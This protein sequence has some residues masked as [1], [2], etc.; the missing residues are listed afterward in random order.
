MEQGGPQASLP[1]PHPLKKE[2]S[3]EADLVLM[4]QLGRGGE[5]RIAGAPSDALILSSGSFLKEVTTL[6]PGKPLYPAP[7]ST[8]NPGPE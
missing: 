3:W 1:P 2:G 6:E 7:L 8:R 5:G 4:W